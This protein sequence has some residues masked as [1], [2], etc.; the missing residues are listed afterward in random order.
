MEKTKIVF[1]KDRPGHDFNYSLNSEKIYK[2][3]KWRP[4]I[5]IDD[6]LKDT[7][8]WYLTNKIFLRKISKKLYE[9]RLGLN[10]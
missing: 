1:V 4:K 7:I 2:Q 8:K 9:K 10:I 5:K 3:I 6:G